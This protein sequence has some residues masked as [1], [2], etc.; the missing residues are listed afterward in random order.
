M[1]AQDIP[2]ALMKTDPAL[3]IET[4][5]SIEKGFFLSKEKASEERGSVVVSAKA[6]R[7]GL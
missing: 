2:I 1:K 7:N 4:D 3:L 5:P 6:E